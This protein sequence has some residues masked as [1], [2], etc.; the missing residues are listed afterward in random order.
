MVLVDIGLHLKHSTEVSSN[1]LIDL[2]TLE[3]F[4]LAMVAP[5]PV[6]LLLAETQSLPIFPLDRPGFES[7]SHDLLTPIR[8]TGPPKQ[9]ILQLQCTTTLI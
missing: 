9:T 8:A 5:G 1:S 2:I 3:V 4:L 7:L 6:P